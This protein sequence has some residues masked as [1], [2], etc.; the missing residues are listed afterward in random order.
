MSSLALV[1]TQ[2]RNLQIQVFKF[3]ICCVKISH[4]IARQTS[5]NRFARRLAR[6]VLT[7]QI[8]VYIRLRLDVS[9]LLFGTNNREAGFWC[10]C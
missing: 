9:P 4:S 1:Q 7:N 3:D 6:L 10:R 8:L 2:T 5:T